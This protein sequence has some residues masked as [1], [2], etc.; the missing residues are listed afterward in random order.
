MQCRK[1]AGILLNILIPL[2][3]IYL[4]CVWIPKLLSYFLP[5]VI[6]W[7]IA[8]IANP[9]VRFLERRLKIVRQHGSVVLIIAVLAL[10]ITV[11]YL[12]VSRG[13]REL[14]GFA[15]ELPTLYRLVQTEVIRAAERLGE[16][17][18]FLPPQVEQTFYDSLS[19]L[20]DELGVIIQDFAAQAGS[21][22]AKTIPDVFVSS[23]VVL[24]S[25]YFFLA[26]HDRILELL[27]KY[28]PESVKKY[29]RF[30]KRDLRSVVGGYLL[31][32]FKIMFVVGV[33]LF[34]GFLFLRV[35]Y[36]AVL[37]FLVAFLDFLPMFGTGTALIPWALVKLITGEYMYALWLVIIWVV[38]QAVRQI[39]QPKIVGD[40]MGLPPLASLFL[41]FVGYRIAGLGG[42]ILSMPVGILL[43]RFY[44]YG[45]FDSLFLN[46]RL[47]WQEIEAVRGNSK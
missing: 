15:A 40:T 41:L 8:M 25:S 11:L 30:L 36:S 12:L 6:G 19:G 43:I 22:V 24:L 10:V 39:I 16:L 47:L 37:A 34:I 9:P 33:I 38:T 17:V 23:I 26:D 46:L 27:A 32:Q 3:T 4:V 1:I 31:A 28:A 42:M 7:V 2:I 13:I 5:F 29:A 14:A 21:A 45:A 35:N 44:G 18:R 20:G